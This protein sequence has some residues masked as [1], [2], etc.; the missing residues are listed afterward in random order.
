MSIQIWS[1]SFHLDEREKR[2]IKE[3][4]EYLPSVNEF[5]RRIR[6]STISQTENSE[7]I[8][9]KSSNL[10]LHGVCLCVQAK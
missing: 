5:L 8:A 10:I 1:F 9:T 4:K 6:R 7:L 3:L 2:E